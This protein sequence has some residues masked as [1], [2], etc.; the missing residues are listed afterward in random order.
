MRA[1][2][3]QLTAAT[4]SHK[5]HGRGDY[6]GAAS[7]AAVS[8]WLCVN[9]LFCIRRAPPPSAEN[10]REAVP[11]PRAV[12]GRGWRLSGRRVRANLN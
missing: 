7:R 2:T 12:T 6:F 3:R 1:L 9:P 8:L 5:H 10:A 4:L 11:S